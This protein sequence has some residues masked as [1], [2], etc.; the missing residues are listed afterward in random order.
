MVNRH[1][2]VFTLNTC[3]LSDAY[4]LLPSTADFAVPFVSWLAVLLLLGTTALC[5]WLP[6]RYIVM[7]M[8]SFK[9]AKGLLFP[10]SVSTH[11][12]LNVLACVPD[13][14]QLVSVQRGEAVCRLPAAGEC[15]EGRGGVWTPSSW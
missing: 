2:R 4:G 3:H 14:Q 12:L 5:Y 10:S 9:F 13:S 11:E 8:G 7:L 6:V 1:I 15:P